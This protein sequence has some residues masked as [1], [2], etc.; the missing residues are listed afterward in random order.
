M[1]VVCTTVQRTCISSAIE[2][3]VSALRINEWSQSVSMDF[4]LDAEVSIIESLF[5]WKKLIKQVRRKSTSRQHLLTWYE[6]D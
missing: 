4:A 6:L 5:H 1:N 3:D 2:L